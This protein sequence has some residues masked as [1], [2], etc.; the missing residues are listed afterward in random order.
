MNLF[1]W[2][3]NPNWFTFYMGGGGSMPSSTTAYQTS[4]PE[5]AKPYVETM[6]GSTQ[7]ELMTGTGTGANFKPTGFRGYTPFGSTFERDQYGAPILNS[8]GQV[9]FTNTPEEQAKA[10][11]AGFTPAQQYFQEQIFDYQAPSQTQAASGIASNLAAQNLYGGQYNPLVA[12]RFQLG[13][14]QQIQAGGVFSDSFTTP[15]VSNAYMS[16]FMQNVVDRQIVEARRQADI[17]STQRGAQAVGQGAFGGSRQAIMDAEAA[18]NLAYQLGDIQAQGQQQAYQQAMAQFNAEQAA[19]LQAQQANQQAGLSA[20]QA[21]QQANLN[22]AIQNLAAQQEAQR[23][24]EASRQFGA[25]L[26][27]QSYG[28]SLQGASLLGQMGQQQFGQDM[29]VLQSQLAEGAKQQQLQQQ[30][31][32]QQIQNYAT[33]QQYPLMQLGVMSNMLRGLPMRASDITQYQARPPLA[34]QA[35]GTATQLYGLNRAGAFGGLKKGGIVQN[36]AD[37]G[38]IDE[39]KYKFSSDMELAQIKENPKYQG[40]IEDMLVTD[41]IKRRN[42]L[43]S[44]PK[45]IMYAKEGGIMRFANGGNTDSL[46]NFYELHSGTGNK[47]GIVRQI[48]LGGSNSNLDVESQPPPKEPVIKNKEQLADEAKKK[49]AKENKIISEEQVNVGVKPV[50]NVISDGTQTGSNN[51]NE[52]SFDIFRNEFMGSELFD[53][54]DF[55]DDPEK[56][57]KQQEL[58]LVQKRDSDFLNTF[59]DNLL[60]LSDQ[61]VGI[62]IAKGG[63]A[64]ATSRFGIMSGLTDG[65]EAFTDETVKNKKARDEAKLA[66]TK[67][68]SEIRNGEL[69]MIDNDLKRAENSRFKLANLNTQLFNIFYNQKRADITERRLNELEKREITK[70]NQEDRKLSLE[71]KKAEVNA[72]KTLLT[73][74]YTDS[75]IYQRVASRKLPPKQRDKMIKQEKKEAANLRNRL[76]NLIRSSDDKVKKTQGGNEVK[77]EYKDNK[78]LPVKTKN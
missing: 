28:Q 54:K 19:N 71:E 27:L 14:P 47:D 64:F 57:K 75:A 65:L 8:Q 20:Q 40:G 24:Q 30:L 36:Y 12:E 48:Y 6:L 31:I 33:A 68:R 76:N 13:S 62:A 49:L 67:I 16:P 32:N 45:P 78:L 37:G 41:E 39:D 35:L 58:M 34:Q 3:F 11:V 55:Q 29:G 53:A 15:G 22:A 44:I 18:R 60:N 2:L 4:I 1:K 10:T 77:Y 69:A 56:L 5:Y 63:R 52:R 42:N 66:L 26:G 50:D 7:R 70:I 23:Q 59:M 17:A 73:N 51:N 38:P 46:A 43:R 61:D 25:N 21:N 9:I 72:I 74:D